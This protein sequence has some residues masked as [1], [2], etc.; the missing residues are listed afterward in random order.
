MK[1]LSF[2]K[3]KIGSALIL[4]IMIVMVVGTI[5]FTLSKSSLTFLNRAAGV[6]DYNYAGQ[7]AEASLEY[8][9]YRYKYSTGHNDE[10]VDRSSNNDINDKVYRW[11]MGTMAPPAASTSLTASTIPSSD[12][13]G[14][15]KN[16][17]YDLR[18]WYKEKKANLDDNNSVITNQ[19][20]SDNFKFTAAGSKSF[21]YDLPLG[22]TNQP[23]KVYYSA[24]ITSGNIKIRATTPGG[25]SGCLTSANTSGSFSTT[26]VS[27]PVT[28]STLTID[29]LYSTAAS[30]CASNGTGTIYIGLDPPGNGLIDSRRTKIESTGIYGKVRQKVTA[31]VNRSSGAVYREKVEPTKTNIFSNGSFENRTGDNFDWW[32]EGASPPTNPPCAAPGSVIAI[33][34]P[35]ADNAYHSATAAKLTMNACNN[36]VYIVSPEVLV[37]PSTKYTLSFYHRETASCTPYMSIRQVTGGIYLQDDTIT[38]SAVYN[39]MPIPFSNVWTRY[40]LT[41]STFQTQSGF[42]IQEF[43]RGSG[44]ASQSIY[45][46]AIQL[47]QGDVPTNFKL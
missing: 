6:S 4:G 42:Q 22:I 31:W 38:W 1:I 27:G 37:S 33:T 19:V 23:I 18:I 44:C 39:D 24:N 21:S 32:A 36:A 47:E 40:Q 7:A 12:P 14:D 3:F 15:P 11:E 26:N 34:I 30:G 46:D 17:Y 43:K 29:A 28:G 2:K 10:I 9:F 8:G 16:Q 45:V 13:T 20:D 5:A 35:P 41:L 25:D